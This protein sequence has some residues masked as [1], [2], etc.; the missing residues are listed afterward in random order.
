MRFPRRLLT[1]GRLRLER[2]ARG[3]HDSVTAEHWSENRVV[4]DSFAGPTIGSVD[5]PS[6]YSISVIVGPL[7]CFIPHWGD[8]PFDLLMVGGP[9]YGNRNI[10]IEAKEAGASVGRK[11]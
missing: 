7:R 4:R 3:R 9:G 2:C 8:G 11:W 1:G 10:V 6:G 5:G